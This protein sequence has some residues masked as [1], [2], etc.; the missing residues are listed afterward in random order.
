M[1]HPPLSYLALV[2]SSSRSFSNRVAYRTGFLTHISIPVS[3][4]KIDHASRL[5]VSYRTQLPFDVH[6]GIIYIGARRSSFPILLRFS[7]FLIVLR[8]VLTLLYA[9]I[10]RIKNRLDFTFIRVMSDPITVRYPWLILWY[11]LTLLP[12]ISFKYWIG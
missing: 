4:I 1:W 3:R 8:I 11:C 12:I 10:H 5:S 7:S 6:V 9:S 2:C